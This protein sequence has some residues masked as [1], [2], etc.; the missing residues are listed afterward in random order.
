MREGLCTTFRERRLDASFGEGPGILPPSHP[1]PRLAAAALSCPAP[2]PRPR[3]APPRP[4]PPLPALP[5]SHLEDRRIVNPETRALLLHSLWSLLHEDG[6]RRAG[7]SPPACVL[8]SC[9]PPSLLA[10]HPGTP[11]PPRPPRPPPLHALCVY[12]RWGG[13]APRPPRKR[14]RC[15]RCALAPPSLPLPP[16]PRRATW[17]WSRG[18]RQCTRAS[19]PP[20]C[21]SWGS[22]ATGCKPPTC[23]CF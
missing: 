16:P 1:S 13:S 2:P 14:R 15:P 6:V 17:A 10:C 19:S 20:C 23:C 7:P 4:H 8:V 12:A 22:S 18:S 5:P 21:A 3:A 11:A 9:V